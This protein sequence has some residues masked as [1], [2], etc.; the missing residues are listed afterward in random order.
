ML[1]AYA[2][3][4][5][6]RMPVPDTGSAAQDLTE[7]MAALY[8]VVHHPLRMESL[9]G[10]MAAAQLDPDFRVAFT[11]WTG[12]RRAVVADLLRRGIAT[13][14]LDP[15]LDVD[16]AADL[17]FGPFWYRM[18]VDHAPL[19]PAQAAGHL[20]RLLAGLRAR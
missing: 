9:R 14:E 2:R 12:T 18:L 20:T 17:I 3:T 5:A 1:E 8:A 15:G 7:F 19:D 4:V 16:Y 13:G 6:D 11:A 10:M